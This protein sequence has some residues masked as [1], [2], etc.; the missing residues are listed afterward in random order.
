VPNLPLLDE[1]PAL[2]RVPRADRGVLRSPIQRV[3][4]P[5]G[6]ATNWV[7]RDDLNAPVLGGNKVR[8]LEFLLAGVEPG[9]ELL[10][11]GGVGST[12]VLATVLHGQRLG[13]D[14]TV[15]RWPHEMG[16]VADMGSTAELVADRTATACARY[17]TYANPLAAL[18]RALSLRLRS[19]AR[20]I[21]FGGNSPVG[22][23]GHV[24]AGFELADQI[25]SGIL[26]TPTRVVVALGTG[27]TA[28]GLALGCA[29][30]E[31]NT[32]VV[33]ARVGPSVV[34]DR[35]RLGWLARRTWNLMRAL[36]AQLGAVTPQLRL[37]VWHGAYAGAYGRALRAADPDARW[38]TSALRA[39][40][41]ATYTAKACY[42]ALALA[43]AG[44][45]AVLY[46]HT[47]DGRWM[48]SLGAGRA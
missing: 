16:V 40:L 39:P 48:P 15:I 8:A 47:F 4:A 44:S 10:T 22:M 14:T 11:V 13:A 25:R 17:E 42:A 18:M 12:H 35:A 20:W 9:Q 5:D 37:S 1:Y 2:A 45:D 43:R 23:L 36:G 31:V 6:S 29:L 27:G 38:M 7:K 32:E 3:T 19:R 28:A 46:W 26:P 33:A 30:A 41:D 34:A 21:P 24:S